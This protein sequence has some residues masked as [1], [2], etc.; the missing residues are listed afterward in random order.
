MSD[1]P[2]SLSTT[3]RES[4]QHGKTKKSLTE[5]MIPVRKKANASIADLERAVSHHLGDLLLDLY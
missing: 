5:Q 3:R 2:V 1:E 4:Q